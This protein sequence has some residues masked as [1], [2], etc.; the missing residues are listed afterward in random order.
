MHL[1]ELRGLNKRYRIKK[2]VWERAEIRH[3]V[4]DVSLHVDEGEIVGL[5]G[6]N[7]AGKTTSFLMAVG[8]LRPDSGSVFFDNYFPK[9][10]P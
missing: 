3:V 9:P 1:L 10:Q 2:S 5:L 6:P 8:M 4:R 7:G